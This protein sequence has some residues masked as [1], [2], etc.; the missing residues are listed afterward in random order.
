MM[1]CSTHALR[2][3]CLLTLGMVLG[4]CP[5]E[6]NEAEATTD[7]SA[8]SAAAPMPAAVQAQVDSG[9]LAYRADDFESALTHFR[10]ALGDA[11]D[12]PAPLYGVYLAATALGDSVLADSVATVLR[13]E[14][15][16]L[17]ESMGHPTGEEPADPHAG[18]FRMAVP[19]SQADTIG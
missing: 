16:W 3:A 17:L 5:S 2:A 19:D 13:D 4:G 6:E 7:T 1:N 10:S 15:P 9:N 8:V 12:R 14:A 11:P 18:M